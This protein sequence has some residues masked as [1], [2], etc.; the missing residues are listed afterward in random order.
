MAKDQAIM[1]KVKNATIW[2][3]VTQLITKL[4]SPI[5]N[6][7]LARLLA[8]ESFGVVAT[9]TIVLSLSDVFI[10]AGFPKYLVQHE[11][12][13]KEEESDHANVALWST[14][15]CSFLLWVLII[16]FQHPIAAMVGN[17]ALSHVIVIS[18]IQL[19]MNAF[20]SILTALYIRNFNYED[21]FISKL[22]SALIPFF[23][24]IP[25]ACFGLK[26]WSI[27][28]GSI[29]GSIISTA[30][31]FVK[32]EWK[33]SF[34]YSLKILKA[35]ISF[36]SWSVL[37]GFFLWLT[38]WFDIIVI[39]NVFSDHYLGLYITSYNMVNAVMSMVTSAIIPVL[40]A[41]LSRMQND[42]VLFYHIFLKCQKSVAYFLFP[43]G[44]GIFLYRDLVTSIILGKK[45]SEASFIIG[46]YALTAAIKITLVNINI[47]AFKAIGQPRLSF[48][49]QVFDLM[50]IVPIC[51]I[52]T[53]YG[54]RSLVYA[55]ALA[56]L[57]LIIPGL[58]IA[59]VIMK[60]K[61]RG[62]IQN[63][64]SPILCTISITVLAVGLKQLNTSIYWQIVSGFICIL[65]YIIAIS[66]FDL[67]ILSKF[68]ILYK[69]VKYKHKG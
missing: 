12:H 15:V 37:E 58:I 57:D 51:M 1:I 10:D 24:T 34:F 27:I 54:F 22:L 48:L 67:S 62:F 60:H 41:T 61:I 42:K 33:P 7:I 40:F 30:M 46:I 16:L 53:K 4:F 39:G 43:I 20:N 59:R 19:P 3:T 35:M 11:F 50:I 14:L 45:W 68:Y 6:I 25:L 36:S 44:V 52:S 17:P 38:T 63:I 2:S 32:S 64:S 28:I 9:V 13:N 47:E 21:I 49:L 69:K 8:P 56:R 26:H 65:F 31:L 29:V 18:C 5:T 55:R 23:V 66:I